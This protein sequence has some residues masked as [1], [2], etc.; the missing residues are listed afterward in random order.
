MSLRLTTRSAPR[1]QYR[2]NGK[3]GAGLSIQKEADANTLDT[4]KQLLEVMESIE[5]DPRF[6]IEFHP[7]FDQ[8]KLISGALEDLKEAALTGGVF[9]MFVLF[10]FLRNITMT[11]L[12]A[13]I[14]FTIVAS[15]AAL[16]LGSG[17]LNLLSLMGLMIAVGMVVDNAIVVVEAIYA[18]RVEGEEKL[19][20]PSRS[21]RSGVSDYAFNNHHT[22]C[23]SPCNTDEQ[24]HR[25]C[26]FLGEI[27]FPNF[28]GP[29]CFF[30][31]RFGLYSIN[32]NAA[33]N[34][35]GRR[36]V[37]SHV[38]HEADKCV[39]KSAECSPKQTH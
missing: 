10:T 26:L 13:C 9:A 29:L 33:P 31:G 38:D 27:G 15:V 1:L 34:P 5:A 35:K 14:P 8:G 17:S 32:H 39:S 6:P 20:P 36:A 4:S 11:L 22:G 30:A 18:R 19:R 16:Y 12:I 21:F 23:I 3:D 7:F 37:C 2:I 24:G 25:L 28:L